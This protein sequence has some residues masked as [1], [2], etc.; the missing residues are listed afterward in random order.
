[1]S[2]PAPATYEP[3]TELQATA[4]TLIEGLPGIG[5][6][7]SIAVDQITRQ[8]DLEHH[9]NITSDEFPPVVTFQHGMVRDL[10]RVYAGTDPDVLTLQS[11][12]SLPPYSFEPLAR[13][14]IEDVADEFSRA[15]FIAGV[16][17][18]SESH[19]GEVAGVGTTE[20]M[21]EELEAAGIELADDP[22]LVGGITGAIVKECYHADV[23]AIVL[24]V[25]AHPYLPDPAAARKL[26]ETALEPLVDFSIDTA[27]LQAE[28][29]KIQQQLQQLAQQYQQML[30]EHQ[31]APEEA[32]PMPSMYQ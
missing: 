14:L 20:A 11:D 7:A 28:A 18:E 15:I 21:C 24:L 26:I 9:G 4:P 12:L 6:V 29:D 1:M 30:Q 32:R 17:A 16:P 25:R 31:G 5:L 13:C 22:G 19:I 10:V 3:L 27:E 23:P 8:L 2:S